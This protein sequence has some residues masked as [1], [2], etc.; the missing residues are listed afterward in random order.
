MH[1]ERTPNPDSVKWV[2][3]RPVVTSGG[4]ARFEP[5]IA[6]AVSPLAA[7]LL[8]VDGVASVLL[9][10]DFVTV[11]K[12]AEAAWSALAD[13]INTALRAWADAD[14][15]AFGDAYVAPVVG[16]E[17]AVVKRI[18]EI[19]EAEIA[20]YVAADGGEVELAGYREGVVEVILR[21]ACESCPSSTITLKMG[22]EA[23]LREEIPEIRS[24]IAV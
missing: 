11:N 6:H 22:I 17:E 9:G 5:G 15:P 19:L 1:A 2:L 8:A 14:E 20:P 10:S 13:P 4:F 7:R 16:D 18:R 3:D 12:V 21:G 24:V 23:R